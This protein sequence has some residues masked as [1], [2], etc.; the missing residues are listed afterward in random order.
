MRTTAIIYCTDCHGSSS[1]AKVP[2][3]SSR[4][5][6]LVGNYSF[7]NPDSTAESPATYALCYRCHNRDSIRRN[8]SF[9]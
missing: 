1:G 6:M 4:A 2:H 5:A 9:K 3:G 7:E 8:D